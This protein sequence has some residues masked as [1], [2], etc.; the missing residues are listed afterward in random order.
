[1]T[2]GVTPGAGRRRQTRVASAASQIAV[3]NR[4]HLYSSYDNVLPGRGSSALPTSGS[5]WESDRGFGGG[6]AWVPG[7]GLGSGYHR[8]SFGRY[9]KNIVSAWGYALEGA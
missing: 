5:D 3:P 8:E 7:G 9:S 6:S 2:K 4:N 1:M